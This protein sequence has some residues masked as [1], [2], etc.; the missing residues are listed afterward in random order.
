LTFRALIGSFCLLSG[1]IF[2]S[3]AQ[4]VQ[5]L[6]FSQL[7][8]ALAAEAKPVF[9]DFTTSW[10]TYCRKM[11]KQVFTKAEVVEKLKQD[12]YAVKMDA[13]TRE[14]IRFDGQEW[15]NKQATDKRDGIHE[16]ALLLGAKEGE[17][18]PPAMLFLSKDFDIK[19]RYFEYLSSKRLLKYLQQY[20]E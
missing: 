19:G 2:S 12:Y 10:C 6:S 4:E 9:I 20:A 11:D 16:L 14:V 3:Q 18:V 5:W 7:D 15:S 17:F 8:S 13:E 1:V